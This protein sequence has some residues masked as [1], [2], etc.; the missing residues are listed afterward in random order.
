MSTKDSKNPLFDTFEAK[1]KKRCLE[2]KAQGRKW[3]DDIML[4]FYGLFK[5]ATVGPTK[6]SAEPWRIELEKHA[7]WEAHFAVR[8]LS[9]SAAQQQYVQDAEQWLNVL[10]GDKIP[11]DYAHRVTF[12]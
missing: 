7:K 3:P 9:S 10:Q 4:H 1:M 5:Q 2:D 12:L 8:S 11:D 6:K